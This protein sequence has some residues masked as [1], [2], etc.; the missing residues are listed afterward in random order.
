MRII[1]RRNKVSL[2]LD[3]D[4]ITKKRLGII[5]NNLNNDS[6]NFDGQKELDIGWLLGLVYRQQ[7]QIEN[8]KERCDLYRELALAPNDLER[9]KIWKTWKNKQ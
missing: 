7:R 6:F 9:W 8:L 4:D 5:H 3:N 1:T 2:H